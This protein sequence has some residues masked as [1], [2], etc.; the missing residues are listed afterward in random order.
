MSRCL[1]CF[2]EFDSTN[3]KRLYCCDKCGNHF[4]S[5]KHYKANPKT[6]EEKR[7]KLRVQQLENQILSRA[8]YRA[9]SNNIA[10]NI[11]KDDIVVPLYCPVLGIKIETKFGRKGY[12]PDSPSL[13]RIRPELGYIK[14]NVRIISAR[15]NLLKNN[16]TIEELEYVLEDLKCVLS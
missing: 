10:F 12:H 13:D 9:K 11:T 14:G 4:R 15:A 6:Y 1:N 5:K 8:K 16:A 3:T 7:R 2:K